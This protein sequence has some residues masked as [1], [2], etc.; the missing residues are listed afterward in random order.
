M[1]PAPALVEDQ[2]EAKASPPDDVGFAAGFEKL[3]VDPIDGL[4][5]EVEAGCEIGEGACTEVK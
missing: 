2:S 4:A 5:P 1:I 3:F